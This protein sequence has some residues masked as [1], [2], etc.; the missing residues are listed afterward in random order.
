MSS[1]GPFSLVGADSGPKVDLSGVAVV[2]HEPRTEVRR[3]MRLA[4]HEFGIGTVNDVADFAALQEQVRANPFDLLIA[5]MEAPDGDVCGLLRA[6]RYGDIGRDPF[7]P[8]VLSAWNPSVGLVVKAVNAGADDLLGKPA[9]AGRLLERVRMVARSRRP[10][11]AACDYVGPERRKNPARIKPGDLI[12]VPNVLANKA[13]GSWQAQAH[14]E[15][16][17]DAV[18]RVHRALSERFAEKLELLAEEFVEGL[19]DSAAEKRAATLETLRSLADNLEA[20]SRRIALPTL[21]RYADG[22]RR[23]VKAFQ[24]NVTPATMK[25]NKALLREIAGSIAAEARRHAG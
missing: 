16:L 6:I 22:L 23:L 9:S 20:H 18:V 4:L 25:R 3:M 15:A 2:V 21:A 5:E 8:A 17:D 13:G 7:V 12:E 11:V 14:R 24:G 1:P 10:F 19:D